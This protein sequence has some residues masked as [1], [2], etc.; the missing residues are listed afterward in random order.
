[1]G[2]VF[3]AIGAEAATVALV[4]SGLLLHDKGVRSS[5]CDGQKVCSSD[6]LDANNRIKSLAGWNAGAYALAAVGLGVGAFL[7][8]TNPAS[9]GATRTAIGVGPNGSGVGLDLRRTF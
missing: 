5:E 9:D 1:M 7:V 3:I 6:G 8:L 2:W 4:T